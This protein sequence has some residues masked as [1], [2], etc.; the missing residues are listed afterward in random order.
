MLGKCQLGVV[1]LGR[2]TE[3]EVSVKPIMS[4]NNLIDLFGHG[5][6]LAVRESG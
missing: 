1:K 2:I 6:N 4:N 3:P 5:H